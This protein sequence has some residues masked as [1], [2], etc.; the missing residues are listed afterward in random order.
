[1]QIFAKLTFVFNLKVIYVLIRKS[2][3]ILIA[4]VFQF[5][6]KVE[7]VWKKNDLIVLILLNV[8]FNHDV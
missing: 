1:M 2:V 5:I 3:D 8:I 7:T 6:K 4:S